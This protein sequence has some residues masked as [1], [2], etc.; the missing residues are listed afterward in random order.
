MRSLSEIVNREV[1][2]KSDLGKYK[3]TG[4]FG[5]LKILRQEEHRYLCQQYGEDYVILYSYV[6]KRTQRKRR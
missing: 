6:R 2:E 1:I 4:A 3:I 5:E